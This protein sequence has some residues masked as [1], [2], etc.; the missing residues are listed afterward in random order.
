MKKM[1]ASDYFKNQVEAK[2]LNRGWFKRLYRRT[3]STAAHET[4]PSWGDRPF[5][6]NF[7]TIHTTARAIASGNRPQKGEAAEHA[8][9]SRP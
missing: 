4:V 9:K 6:Y 3:A 5:P 7:K 2:E 1:K 8:I